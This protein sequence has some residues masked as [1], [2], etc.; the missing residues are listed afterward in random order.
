MA[1]VR[2]L[3]QELARS[4]KGTTRNRKSSTDHNGAL[5]FDTHG[6]AIAKLTPQQ[7][8][9]NVTELQ[10]NWK[11]KAGLSS[12]ESDI[13]Y[14]YHVAR[15]SGLYRGHAQVDNKPPRSVTNPPFWS[16]TGDDLRPIPKATEQL[17]RERHW[18]QRFAVPEKWGYKG[19]TPTS[20][21]EGKARPKSAAASTARTRHHIHKQ[22][23]SVASSRRRPTSAHHRLS[24]GD[25]GHPNHPHYEARSSSISGLA[26]QQQPQAEPGFVTGKNRIYATSFS[27]KRH[28]CACHPTHHR[29]FDHTVV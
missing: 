16:T 1:S 23:A 26:G 22:A 14:K 18:D 19:T 6:Y 12:R 13:Q 27:N 20:L 7:K 21:Q 24:S 29:S 10:Q 2:R 15:L 5:E 11:G 4:K 8:R 28:C 25:S 3:K 17:E 9:N